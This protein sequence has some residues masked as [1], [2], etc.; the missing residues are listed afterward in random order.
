MSVM[1][2][3]TGTDRELF[4]RACDLGF[5]L[6]PMTANVQTSIW[7]ATTGAL[8]SSRRQWGQLPRARD[9]KVLRLFVRV[10]ANTDLR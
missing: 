6:M 7:P 10:F 8:Q 2:A 4:M 3:S 9:D 5:T 1:R